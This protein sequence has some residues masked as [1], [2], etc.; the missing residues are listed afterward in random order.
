MLAFL[1][2][3]HTFAFNGSAG[4]G[5]SLLYQIK[6]P[7]SIIKKPEKMNKIVLYFDNIIKKGMLDN[8]PAKTAP[9]PTATNNAGKAQQ[10][11]VPR[12][13]NRLIEGMI[14]FFVDIGLIHFN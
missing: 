4:Q 8:S 5:A 6:K 9:A 1:N 11:K 2:R 10:I 7:L 3:L 12:L 13:V 14:R